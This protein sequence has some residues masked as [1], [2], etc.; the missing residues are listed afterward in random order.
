MTTLLMVEC[1][2]LVSVDS[3]KLSTAAIGS[4]EYSVDD[5]TAGFIYRENGWDTTMRRTHSITPQPL[6]IDQARPLWVVD[7]HAGYNMPELYDK[8]STSFSTSSYSTAARRFPQDLEGVCIELVNVKWSRRGTDK[9]VKSQR[10]GDAS[11]TLFDGGLPP[12]SID[13]L[14]RYTRAY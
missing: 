14:Q 3:V 6:S 4:S 1:T 12:T 11:E 7:Y 9:S 10:T 2:P 8:P 13:V 5:A